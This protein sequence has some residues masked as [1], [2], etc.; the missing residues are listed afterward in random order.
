MYEFS[1]HLTTACVSVYICPYI[2]A[3]VMHMPAIVTKM[4]KNTH[5]KIWSRFLMSCRRNTS[6]LNR[7]KVSQDKR[8]HLLSWNWNWTMCVH[9]CVCHGT[10]LCVYMY[11]CVMELDYVCTCMCVVRGTCRSSV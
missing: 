6:F 2:S 8:Y 7:K 5:S 1:F 9:V 4:A 10:G 11:V 3:V